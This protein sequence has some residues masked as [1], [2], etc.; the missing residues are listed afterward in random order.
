MME[1]KDKVSICSLADLVERVSSDLFHA[2]IASQN[3][4]DDLTKDIM[5]VLDPAMESL[6]LDCRTLAEGRG[7]CQ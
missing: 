7:K 1:H 4:R 5:D 3:M 6:S 2:E